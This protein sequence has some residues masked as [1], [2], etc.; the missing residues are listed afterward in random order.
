MNN[1]LALCE[2]DRILLI[3]NINWSEF[4]QLNTKIVICVSK[5][6]LKRSIKWKL[7]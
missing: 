1:K 6:G 3:T 7:R 4:L 2:F 5:Q